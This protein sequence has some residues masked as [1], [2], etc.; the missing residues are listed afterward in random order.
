VVRKPA[1]FRTLHA[2]L[3]T[4]R[5]WT[6]AL[7]V[8]ALLGTVLVARAATVGAQAP[9][10]LRQLAIAGGGG[11]GV[12]LALAGGLLLLLILVASIDE[13]GGKGGDGDGGGGSSCGCGG[14]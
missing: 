14:C 6:L 5:A 2:R 4:S 9:G 7:C 1:A 12:V 11:G 13:G 3:R 10:S 8:A